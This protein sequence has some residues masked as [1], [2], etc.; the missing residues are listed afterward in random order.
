MRKI[1]LIAA[2]L[3]FTSLLHGAIFPGYDFTFFETVSSD[4]LKSSE[5]DHIGFDYTGYG[6]IGG[7]MR[8]GIYMRLGFQ[9]P[10]SSL[11]AMLPERENE[12]N[13]KLQENLEK[14][15]SFSISAGPAFRKLIGDDAIWY[16]GL[17]ASYALDYNDR[18]SSLS[19]TKS[20]FLDMDFGF[21]FDIGV[22]LDATESTTVR[23]GVH[24]AFTFFS[25][26]MQIDSPRNGEG[27]R[28]TNAYMTPNM[29]LPENV[30]T[31]LQAEGYISLGHTFRQRQKEKAMRYIISSPESFTG[32]LEEIRQELPPSS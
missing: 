24:G 27:E 8:T 23:I 7:N 13:E 31:P 4:S 14:S 16:M 19:D 1:P 2:L 9:A 22:R 10:Y 12:D 6:F 26:H 5:R 28:H 32:T 20:T 30:K 25:V 15:F 3:L 29:F 21:D 17:G 18:L 11:A